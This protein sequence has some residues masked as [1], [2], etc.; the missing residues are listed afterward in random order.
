M[1]HEQQSPWQKLADLVDGRLSPEEAASVEEWAGHDAELSATLAWLRAFRRAGS[2]VALDEPAPGL[3]ST[4]RAQFAEYVSNS[5]QEVNAG[6]ANT[7]SIIQ[8]LIAALSF[9]S[10]LQPGLEGARGAAE[11][12]RQLVYSVDIADISLTIQ[13]TTDGLNIHGQILPIID[14]TLDGFQAQLRRDDDRIA[15]VFVDAPGHFTFLSV[16]PNRYQLML[17]TD[18]LTILIESI[19]LDLRTENG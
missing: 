9:D 6:E 18:A 19:E 12:M 8:R 11:T 16:E 13:E 1:N 4:L 14:M 5:V 3:R 17:G 15:E 10:G 2:E 7:S